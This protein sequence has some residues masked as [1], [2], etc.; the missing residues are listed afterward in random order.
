LAAPQIGQ[1][2]RLFIVDSKTTYINLDTAGR[3][4]YFTNDDQGTKETF[5]NARITE[6]SGEFWEDQE[7]CLS[8]PGVSQLIK[9]PWTITI[10]YSNAGFEKQSKTFSGATARMIQHEYDHTEG[11]LYI[12]YLKPLTRKL[13]ESRLKKISKGQIKAGYPIL[14]NL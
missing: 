1:A 2:V 12:D 7:G 3:E 13:L 8:I 4:A 11:I 9:R 6:R 14:Y 10:E 5:I